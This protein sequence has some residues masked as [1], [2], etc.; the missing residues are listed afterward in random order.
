MG[1][2]WGRFLLGVHIMTFTLEQVSAMAGLS[3]A[4]PF[5]WWAEVQLDDGTEWGHPVDALTTEQGLC[6]NNVTVLAEDRAGRI[7][8]GTQ[9]A[10][11][12]IID[13][14]SVSCLTRVDGLPHDTVFSLHPS[15][16]GTLL[17]GTERGL[18]RSVEGI[19]LPVHYSEVDSTRPVRALLED[20][21]GRLW[22]GSD[23]GL[24]LRENGQWR[25][26]KIIIRC[27]G[28]RCIRCRVRPIRRARERS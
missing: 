27:P 28:A 21:R 13:H 26:H 25:A 12:A 3:D 2:D 19:Q 5:S 24:H 4:N 1:G 16:D 20:S 15:A 10:G 7:L 6:G 22:V 11:L 14:G 23:S 9:G 17:I 8:A 18:V